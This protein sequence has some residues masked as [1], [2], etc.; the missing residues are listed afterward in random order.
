MGI[1]LEGKKV[2][3][4][5]VTKEDII[6]LEQLMQ[7]K[8]IRDLVGD[9]YPFTEKEM[10]SYLAKCQDLEERIWLVIIDKKK[11]KLI[12]ETGFKYI[13]STWRNAGFTLIIWDK[14]YWGNGYGKEVAELMLDYGF[15]HL[16]LHRIGIEV[17]EFNENG[18]KFWEHIGFTQEGKEKEAYYCNGK[19]YDFIM[20]YLLE[21]DYRKLH[22]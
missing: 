19:Y 22:P 14:K 21:N 13:H 17:V 18:L 3:L 9:I 11:K 6:E 7:D 16:N 4:K 5:T 1:F 10:D 2:I 15:N 8:Q 12:G 20:M